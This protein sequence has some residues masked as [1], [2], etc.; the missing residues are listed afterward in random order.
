MKT[1]AFILLSL[2]VA[3]FTS[4]ESIKNDPCDDTVKPEIKVSLQATVHVLDKDNLPIP[5]QQLNFYIYKVPCGA[6]AKGM[7]Q[8]NGKTNAEG[9]RA[10]TTV[11]YNLRNEEDEIWVDVHAVNLGNGSVTDDSEYAIFKYNDF[12]SS[13]TTKQVHVF[14]YKK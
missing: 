3:W 14:I 13:I 1:P 7:F 10:S 8:F 2:F 4:C 6:A 12:V 5:D 9:I 11:Y